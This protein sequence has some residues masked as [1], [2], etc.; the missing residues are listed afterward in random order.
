M[1]DNAT[2]SRPRIHRRRIWTIV[3]SAIVATVTAAGVITVSMMPAE[4]TTT[5]GIDVS[6]YQGTIN[7]T[8]AKNSGVQFAYIKSTEG[9]SYVDPM[10]DTY[11]TGATTAKV[12]RGAYHFALPDRSSGATQADF[13]YQNGGG[14]SADNLTLPAALDLEYNP[15]GATCYGL[16]Q[17]GMVSWI[18]SFL[19]RY[20]A[21]TGRYAVIYTTTS[22]WNTCTGNSSAF[23]SNYPLWVA[24]YAS[25]TGTLPSGWGVHSFW[26][27][28]DSGSISG[29][30]ASTDRNY[31]NGS[32]TR[33]LALANN[34]A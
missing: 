22:W 16:T 32:R 27:Y 18:S 4:A 33:L 6:H 34:T 29:V 20:Q 26:Q 1:N 24:R 28:T 21:L 17:S 19:D 10:F 14:W 31:F 7:W 3:V 30:S 25:S 11:Y 2:Q 8:T 23:A 15:Y 13:L 9:V 12:I 5:S